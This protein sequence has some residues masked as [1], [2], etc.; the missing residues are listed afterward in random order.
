MKILIVTVAGLSSRFSESVGYS[1][2]K[3][4]YH[5]KSITEALLYKIL[6]QDVKFDRYIIVGGF[7][8]EELYETLQLH[9]ADLLTKITVLKNE[10]YSEYGSGYSLYLGLQEAIQTRFDELIFAEG[11]LFVDSED[12]Q[13]VYYADSDVITCNKEVINAD[14]AVVF[15]FDLNGKIHYIFDTCHNAI[16]ITEPFQAIY[17]SGQIWKFRNFQLLNKIVDNLREEEMQGTNLVIIQKYFCRLLREEY[18]IIE[19]NKWIN[20]NTVSDYERIFTIE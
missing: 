14:K 18:K 12:F 2:L 3:C 8:F 16:F 5:K 20:C 9:F 17:N 13:K 6:R 7:M 15:Y 11:D 4:I 19:F 10:K 1:C